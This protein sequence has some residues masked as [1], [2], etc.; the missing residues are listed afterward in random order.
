M[1]TVML[2]AAGIAPVLNARLDIAEACRKIG[3][4]D[5]RAHVSAT[6]TSRLTVCPYQ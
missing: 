1:I 2:L 4:S 6:C 5:Q 3:I